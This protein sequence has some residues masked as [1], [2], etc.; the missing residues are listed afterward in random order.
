M[1]SL[2]ATSLALGVLVSA[3]LLRP[4]AETQAIRA[5]VAS[6]HALLDRDM[7]DD[8]L[9]LAARRV[10]SGEVEIYGQVKPLHINRAARSVR[11]Q[12]VRAWR[13]H[14]HLPTDG[15]DGFAQAAYGRGFLR[16]IGNDLDQIEAD[17][18]GRAAAEQAQQVAEAEP[19]TPLPQ[20]LRR[21]D[22]ALSEG[23]LPWGQALPPP[24]ALPTGARPTGDQD[25]GS[26]GPER[27]H[28]ALAEIA[29]RVGATTMQSTQ[30]PSGRSPGTPRAGGPVRVAEALERTA[31]N[32]PQPAQSGSYA[33]AP[34]KHPAEETQP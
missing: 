26:Q 1:P 17:R 30:E 16:A 22:A 33:S 15:R 4:L 20:I 28:Q 8:L 24:R 23:R 9:A 29:H 32:R 34:V 2:Q 11:S 21:L 19:H 10:A 18:H 31:A 13:E 7:S 3:D 6:W 25:P 14:H 12:R 5:R 27:A